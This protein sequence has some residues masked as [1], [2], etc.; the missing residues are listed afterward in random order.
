M[1]ALH[2]IQNSIRKAMAALNESH[3]FFSFSH[4]SLIFLHGCFSLHTKGEKVSSWNEKLRAQWQCTFYTDNHFAS[5]IYFLQIKFWSKRK[6]KIDVWEQFYTYWSMF[7]FISFFNAFFSFGFCFYFEQFSPL[8][9]VWI[10]CSTAC[11]D[12]INQCF[13]LFCIA[14]GSSLLN[15]LFSFVF[16][17]LVDSVAKWADNIVKRDNFP[18]FLV[19]LW[20]TELKHPIFFY[21]F[22]LFC[23]VQ[24]FYLWIM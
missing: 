10:A 9:V 4:F 6:I 23:Y 18:F 11:A 19:A 1:L 21:I 3:A 20:H 5:A 8:A 7:S 13:D 24:Y 15:I 22:S 14:V 17:Y 16:F 2:R 12:T